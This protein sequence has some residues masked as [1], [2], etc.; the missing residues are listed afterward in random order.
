MATIYEE[1]IGKKPRFE[2]TNRRDIMAKYASNQ[3]VREQKTKYFDQLWKP[4]AWA[5]ILGFI[6]KRRKPI[7]KGESAFD[8]LTISTNGNDIFNSL[9]LFSI[10][11]EG[12]GI[13]EDADELN[14]VIS[15]YANGGF[16]II[17][18]ILSE[19]GDYYFDETSNFLQ[20]VMD[21]ELVESKIVRNSSDTRND[22][23]N[24]EVNLGRSLGL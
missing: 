4:F 8:Y 12:Y 9:I 19:K 14:S 13:L 15:E 20:E 10:A 3:G 16:D 18:E 23:S 2:I 11:N 6:H 24:K 7:G 1:L 22:F 17:R 21:R 5:A